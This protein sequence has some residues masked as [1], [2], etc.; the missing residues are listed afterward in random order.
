MGVRCQLVQ[1][2]DRLRPANTNST[3]TLDVPKNGIPLY[4]GF[5]FYHRVPLYVTMKVITTG[6]VSD[7]SQATEKPEEKPN[8]KAYTQS[9]TSNHLIFFCSITH[10]YV[11]LFS[12]VAVL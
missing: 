10:L 8:R 4:M 6:N 2:A 11:T 3:K 7:E 9:E 5:V 1:F 12:S